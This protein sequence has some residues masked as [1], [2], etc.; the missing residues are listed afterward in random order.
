MCADDTLDPR[1]AASLNEQVAAIASQAITPSELLDL[2][3]QRI[4]LRQPLLNGYRLVD[5]AGARTAVE[6]A[7]AAL[8][9]GTARGRLFGVPIA[10]KDLLCV[11]GLLTS[12]GS[13]MLASWVSPYDATPVARLKAEGA[14]IVGKTNQDEFAMGN[15]GES[16]A[17]GTTLNPWDLG[18]VAGGSSGG[19]AAVVADFQAAA[20]LGS[21]TGGSI[22]QP[23]SFCGLVG[24]K[25][26]WGRVSRH[27]AIAYASSLDQIGPLGRTTADAALLLE[28]IAGACPHDMHCLPDPV[29]PLLSIARAAEDLRGLRVG[30]PA[31][32]FGDGNAP[33]VAARVDEALQKMRDLGATLVPVSL[34]HTPYAIQ[35]YYLIAMA[36][37]SSNLSRYDGLRYGHRADAASVDGIDG[38][39]DLISA[40]R[41]EGFGPEVKRRI[42]LG[43]FALSAGYRD[44]FYTR[45]QA[46]RALIRADFAAAYATCDLI[47]SP[48]S[49]VTAFPVGVATSDPLASWLMDIDTVMSNLA[50]HCSLSLPIGFDAA[51]LPIGL[52][53]M[54]PHLAEARLVAAAAAYERHHPMARGPLAHPDAGGPA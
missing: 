46:V 11:E 23:A 29:P 33:D 45:A 36:E 12:A 13:R 1:L 19:S 28:V 3:L 2:H 41:A 22:R 26:T 10:V 6:V 31:E 37:A 5:T 52:Q 49:P 30:I 42:L 54:G 16:C 24:I 4:E 27:G 47:A 15:S 38:L 8:K 7:D 25:P 18:R 40:S 48:T 50:G 43:T 9:A 21:D 17:F 51:G 35:T 14:I 53:L 20:A 32:L 34:P 39:D 44:A